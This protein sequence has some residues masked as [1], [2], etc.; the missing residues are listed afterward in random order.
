MCVCYVL[1]KSYLLTYLLA[2]HSSHLVMC[3]KIIF[4]NVN[5]ECADFFVLNIV[6][7]TSGHPY[8]LYVYHCRTNVIR[9]FFRLSYC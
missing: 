5:M 3:Y 2:S 7:F 9:N 6:S 8:K 1:L 4:N